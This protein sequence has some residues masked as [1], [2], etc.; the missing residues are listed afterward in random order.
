MTR[1]KL[2]ENLIE[3]REEITTSLN[4]F[5]AIRGYEDLMYQFYA[6]SNKVNRAKF[7]A[8]GGY[9]LL[10]RLDPKEKK[11]L[12]PTYD[13]IIQEALSKKPIWNATPRWKEETRVIIEAFLHTKY[14]LE[15]AK[16]YSEEFKDKEIPLRMPF[17]WAALATLYGLWGAE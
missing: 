5:N 13:R 16:K 15:Q 6:E 7:Y 3:N 17:G 2:L 1:K 12:E 8:Q 4:S 9:E 14:F 10:K 11:E